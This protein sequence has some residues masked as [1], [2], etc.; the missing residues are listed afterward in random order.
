MASG[1][2][3]GLREV[4]RLA[5]GSRGRGTKGGGELP[6]DRYAGKEPGVPTVSLIATSKAFEAV[7]DVFARLKTGLEVPVELR[8]RAEAGK[9]GGGVAQDVDARPGDRLSMLARLAKRGD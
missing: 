9:A 3:G 1:D 5:A 7:S 6:G 8:A 4:R 2:T